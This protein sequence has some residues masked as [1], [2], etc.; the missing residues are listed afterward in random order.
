MK[1]KKLAKLIVTGWVQDKPSGNT[2]RD[3]DGLEDRIT[4]ALE[5]KEAGS[6]MRWDLPSFVLGVLFGIFGGIVGTSV[7][8]LHR[9]AS[10]LLQ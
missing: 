10:A 4:Q 1:N 7:V 9:T 8:M 2:M 3:Y 6:E 5:D